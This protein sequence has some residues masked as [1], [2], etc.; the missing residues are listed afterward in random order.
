M[1][2][3][4]KINDNVYY[5]NNES[6][7]V[8]KIQSITLDEHGIIYNI[9]NEKT[10][11][12]AKEDELFT[13]LNEHINGNYMLYPVSIKSSK[14]DGRGFNRYE[15]YYDEVLVFKIKSA[16]ISILRPA[17]HQ[18]SSYIDYEC[19]LIGKIKTSIL[20]N[21]NIIIPDCIDTNFFKIDSNEHNQLVLEFNK[22]KLKLLNFVEIYY[23]NDCNKS[24][25]LTYQKCMDDFILSINPNIRDVITSIDDVISLETSCSNYVMVDDKIVSRIPLILNT[26]INYLE[27]GSVQ[28]HI[29]LLNVYKQDSK[30]LPDLYLYSIEYIK[31]SYT[32]LQKI[33][34]D[35][36]L[37]EFEDIVKNSENFSYNE[38]INHKI[39]EIKVS[40]V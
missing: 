35:K 21:N 27:I 22:H 33:V 32:Q 37:L 6:L 8:F 30:V 15:K 9:T 11:L 26:T 19:E 7:E 5:Y 23:N 25:R 17:E 12:I 2:F 4:Y 14:K 16:D 1:N 13:K 28:V 24:H 3:K 29:K 36:L 39:N 38:I 40:N 18:Y 34:T 10:Q 31:L 20:R